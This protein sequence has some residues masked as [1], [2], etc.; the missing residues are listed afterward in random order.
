MKGGGNVISCAFMDLNCCKAK[1][2]GMV[3]FER[4]ICIF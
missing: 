4:H 1:R 3:G 2:G